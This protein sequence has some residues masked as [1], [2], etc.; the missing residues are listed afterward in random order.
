M[1]SKKK[2]K[3]KRK[4]QRVKTLKSSLPTQKK[5]NQLAFTTTGELFQPVRIHY[6]VFDVSKLN[7]LFSSL[8]CMDYDP[9]SKRWVWLYIGEARKLEFNQKPGEEHLIIIGEFLFENSNNIILNLRSHERA[10]NGIVFFDEHIPK[11]VIEVTD[12]TTINRL[13]SLKE[14][15]S[16]GS[17]NKL[18]ETNNLTIRDPEKITQ[19]LLELKNS[20][21]DEAENQKAIS[22]YILEL[23]NEKIPEIEK[24]P[25]NYYEDGIESLRYSLR[26]NQI[27]ALEHWKGNTD[28]NAMDAIREGLK[29]SSNSI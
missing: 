15:T 6:K 4:K 7:T 29:K 25:S 26:L 14:A 19:D 9:D 3:N 1:K 20:S 5:M 27:V 24:F 23:S 13:Y 11:S 17:L 12:I 2:N 18:F 21:D 8:K 28:Y 16:V 22:K 10:I